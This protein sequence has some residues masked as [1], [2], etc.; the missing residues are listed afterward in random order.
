M[1]NKIW[2]W[3]VKTWSAL[4]GKISLAVQIVPVL[5]LTLVSV[6]VVLLVANR[7]EVK[8]FFLRLLVALF[9]AVPAGD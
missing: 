3:L 7:L 8:D 5:S 9:S 2:Q 4:T 1:K 6:L